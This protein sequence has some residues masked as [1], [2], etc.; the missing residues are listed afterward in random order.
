MALIFP[1]SRDDEPADDAPLRFEDFDAEWSETWLVVVR[2]SYD[3]DEVNLGPLAAKTAWDLAVSIDK[4]RPKWIVTVTPLFEA[5]DA[6]T[7]IAT[8]ERSDESL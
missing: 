8:L 5:A 7:V 6:D 4:K 1:T 2:A 3:E